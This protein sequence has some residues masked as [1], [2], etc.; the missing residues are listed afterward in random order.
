MGFDA[1]TGVSVCNATPAEAVGR[2]AAVS[3]AS[4]FVA[5]L[6]FFFAI[7]FPFACPYPNIR[8][9]DDANQHNDVKSGV[10]ALAPAMNWV[11]CP[12]PN[13]TDR[14]DIDPSVTLSAKKLTLSPSHCAPRT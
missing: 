9:C 7:V 6:M 2:L 8:A 14:I 4:C 5:F 11:V 12:Q 13:L 10:A 3:V 1:L